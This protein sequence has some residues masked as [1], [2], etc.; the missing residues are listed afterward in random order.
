MFGESAV[1]REQISFTHVKHT[2]LAFF[3]PIYG[4]LFFTPEIHLTRITAV[5]PR[6]CASPQT[7]TTT[8]LAAIRRC[9]DEPTGV[10]TNRAIDW[11]CAAVD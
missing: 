9:L 3:L 4:V 2:K 1:C 5:I 8:C 7:Q 6:Y 11:V 10:S